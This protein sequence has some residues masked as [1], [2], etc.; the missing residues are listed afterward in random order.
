MANVSIPEEQIHLLTT[1]LPTFFRLNTAIKRAESNN[2]LNE[3]YGHVITKR[4]E[5][6]SQLFQDLFVDFVFSGAKGKR[7]LEFGATDGVELSNTFMLERSREWTG[8]LAE[9]DPQWH[10][11]LKR[12]R[13]NTKIITECIYSTTGETLDFISSARGVLSSL[14][15][16]AFED[17]HAQ[18][19]QGRMQE[20]AEISVDTISLNDVFEEHFNGEPIEYMSVD[21]EGSEYEILSNFNFSKYK[22]TIVT[23][24][25]NYTPA[26][27]KLD[28]LFSNNDYVRVFGSKTDFDAWYVDNSLAKERGFI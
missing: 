16:F 26:Q 17:F 23:V 14:K 25:H 18:N 1:M 10:D 15:E 9:P 22:P 2:L 19:P 21:T 8:V 12:N 27:H 28:T 7:F 20:Y 24:E 3:F 6:H 11:R 4:T 5:S 13:K